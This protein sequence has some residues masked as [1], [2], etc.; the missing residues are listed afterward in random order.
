[1]IR[2]RSTYDRPPTDYAAAH[3]L[4]RTVRCVN[5]EVQLLMECEP[6][7]GYGLRRA[8]WRHT[9]DGYHQALAMPEGEATCR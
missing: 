2:G 8:T 5:G 4:V 1:M 7:F 9:E 3:M 6:A